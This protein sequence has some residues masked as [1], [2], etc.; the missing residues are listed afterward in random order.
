MLGE[1][2]KIPMHQNWVSELIYICTRLLTALLFVIA[3]YQK[4]K[5]INTEPVGSTLV[6]SDN[7]VLK[8]CEKE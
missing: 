1:V 3:K 7:G 6:H 5:N 2:G 4:Q 8:R